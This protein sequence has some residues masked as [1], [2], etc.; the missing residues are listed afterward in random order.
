MIVNLATALLLNAAL[1]I[2]PALGLAVI[3]GS[4]VAP[5]LCGTALAYMAYNVWAFDRF[6]DDVKNVT[7]VELALCAAEMVLGWV[8][9]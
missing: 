7:I 3:A 8:L 5:M 6:T 2:A 1:V 4:A 9:S